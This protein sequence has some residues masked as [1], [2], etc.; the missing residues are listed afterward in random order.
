MQTDTKRKRTANRFVSTGGLPGCVDYASWLS[1]DLLLISGWFQ[2]REELPVEAY[3]VLDGLS[4]PIEV[5]YT[6][7]HRPD[8]PGADLQIGKILTACL[9][10]PRLGLEAL[11]RLVVRAGDTTVDL[12]PP[13]VAD[14]LI[15]LQTFIERSIMPLGTQERAGVMELLDATVAGYQGAGSLRLSR[16]VFE[17]R[18]AIRERLPHGIISPAHSQGLHIDTMLAVGPQSFYI[19][20]WMRDEEAAITRLTAVSPEG[21]RTEILEGLFRFARPDVEQFYGASTSKQLTAKSGFI[22]FFETK[23]PS[24]LLNGW[25]LEM[26]N[27]ASIAVESTVP[28]VIRDPTAVRDA[29]LSDLLRERRAKDSLLGKHTFPAISR[30]QEYSQR[31]VNVD[32]VLQY[33]A[34][35]DA[36]EVSIVVPLYSRVDYLEHQMAQFVHDPQIAQTDLIYVLDSPELADD[37]E[38]AAAKLFRLYRI[39]F[40]LVVLDQNGGFSAAN[41][42]GVALGQ[43]RL[44]LLL[45]SDVLP[46]KPGWLGKLTA[47]YDSTPGIGALGAKLLYEDDSLQHA[48]MYFFRND[49]TAMWENEHYF[50]GFHRSLPAA[51]M[52]R[53]VPAVTAACMLLDRALYQRLG[54]LRGIYVQGDYEDS[55]LCLRLIEAGYENWYLPTAELYHLEG[56]S[57]PGTLR[58]L[59]GQYNLWVHTSLWDEQIKTIMACYEDATSVKG[60]ASAVGRQVSAAIVASEPPHESDLTHNP[61]DADDMAAVSAASPE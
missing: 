43:G 54:G 15:N 42:A 12:A 9:S 51:N 50:K 26:R 61:I 13:E 38:I 40:R 52:L 53:P 49:L 29:I 14:A 7:Y 36:P 1:D 58:Q 56:Q 55:D 16:S 3:L 60:G 27:A 32:R 57:Y 41:N 23:A 25:I 24:C 44:L 59:T 28:A 48:G 47:F 30:L 11:G 33:G 45:N 34:P 37:L 31:S 2:A 19:K 18:E 10:R 20:G 17:I 46:D 5:R 6:S 4:I 39:P 22:A 35:V 21:C 8:I